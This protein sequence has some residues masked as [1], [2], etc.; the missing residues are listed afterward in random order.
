MAV[1][2]HVRRS[3]VFRSGFG[4][5]LGPFIAL[6]LTRYARRTMV[7]ALQRRS[8][9]RTGALRRGWSAAPLPAPRIGVVF[10]NRARHAAYPVSGS[11]DTFE[12]VRRQ[13]ASRRQVRALARRGLLR[14]AVRVRSG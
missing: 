3:G 12:S 7:P 10:D 11:F 2:F 9:V 1:G 4:V 6:E 14:W 13:Y 5:A 8:R